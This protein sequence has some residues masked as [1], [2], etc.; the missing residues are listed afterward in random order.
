MWHPYG[1]NPHSRRN[2]TMC[3]MGI[4]LREEALRRRFGHAVLFPAHSITMSGP[5]PGAVPGGSNGTEGWHC[6]RIRGYCLGVCRTVAHCLPKSRGVPVLNRVFCVLV[7]FWG[8]S[9]VGSGCRG[10]APA[11]WRLRVD[12]EAAPLLPVAASTVA[13]GDGALR[14]GR[15]RAACGRVVTGGGRGALAGGSFVSYGVAGPGRV[16]ALWLCRWSRAGAP[17]GRGRRQGPRGSCGWPVVLSSLSLWVCVFDRVGE[18]HPDMSIMSH[19]L[20]SGSG[21][22][23]LRR[24][25]E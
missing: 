24:A 5:G 10:V 18:S 25:V 19:R 14:A 8:D 11:G 12:S 13:G 4:G 7:C 22:H 3:A 1:S 23:S 9:S 16:V 6:N 2:R 17:R 20:G 15:D 21:S